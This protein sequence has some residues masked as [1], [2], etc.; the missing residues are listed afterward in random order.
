MASLSPPSQHEPPFSLQAAY[1]QEKRRESDSKARKPRGMPSFPG[2]MPAGMGFGG[3]APGGGAGAGG[4]MPDV[5]SL[6][7]VRREARE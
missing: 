1:A 3:G 5:S 6:L 2:G 7:N 4:G